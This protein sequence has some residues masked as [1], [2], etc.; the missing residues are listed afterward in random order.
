M[1]IVE[2]IKQVLEN[3]TQGLTSKQIYEEKVGIG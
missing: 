1:T 2:A 3:K